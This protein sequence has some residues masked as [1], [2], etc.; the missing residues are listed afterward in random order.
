MMHNHHRHL[1]HHQGV[2][3]E[4]ETLP[5]KII[6]SSKEEGGEREREKVSGSVVHNLP[7]KFQSHDF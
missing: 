5:K 4:I 7:S 6:S 2:M 3:T 1:I